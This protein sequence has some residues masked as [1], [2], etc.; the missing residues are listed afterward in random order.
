VRAAARPRGALVSWRPPASDGGSPVTGYVIT[1]SPGGKRARTAAVTSFTVGGLTNGTAYRFTVAAVT[2]AGTGPASHRSAA[3][4]PRASR[5]PGA[6]RS[7]AASAGY[8]QATVTWRAPASDGGAPVTSYVIAARPGPVTQR[9]AGDTRT[10]TLAGLRDGRRYRL[11]VSAVTSAGTGQA[12]ESA[13]VTPRTTVPGPP[14]GVTAAPVSSGVEVSWQPPASNGGSSVSSYVIEVTGTTRKI[15]VRAAARSVVITGLKKG[16]GYGFGVAARN[17]RGTGAAATS[18]RASAGGTVAAATVV[19]SAASLA[20]LAPAQPGG[21]LVFTSPPAQ[22]KGLKTGD[23]LVA[24]VAGATPAGLLARVTS[25]VSGGTKVTVSTVPAS[26]DQALSAAGFGTTAT[27]TRGQVA[28]FR[29]ARAGVRL[30]SQAPAASSGSISLSLDTDLYRAG[31]G[32]KVTLDGT[33]SLT[34]AMTFAASVTCC[35]HTASTFT[36]T[37][38]SA[39]S[40]DLTAQV[41]HDISGGYTLGTF[42]FD[43][44]A[45]DVL[46]VPVVIVPELTVR[47]LASGSVTAG[48]STAAGAAITVGAQVTTKD[49][50]VSAHPVSSRTGSF[51]P[52]VLYGSLAAAAGV[53]AA[54]SATVDGV[55]GVTLTDSLWLAK[56]SADI[57]ANPWWTLSAQ[58]VID[59]DLDLALL[60]HTFASYHATLSDVTARLA[61]APGPYQGITIT[62]DPAAVSPGG[63]LQLH[64]RV[65]GTAAQ[66]VTWAAPTGNGAITAAGRYTAPS[67]P[68]TYQVTASVPARGLSPAAA[69]E[70]SVQVGDQP[71]G[72]P[73]DAAA[74]AA[75]PGAARVTWAAPADTGGGRVTGYT[76]TA[77]PGGTSIQAAGTARSVSLAGLTPGS[78][79]T[80]TVA[81]TGA[82][83]AGLPSAATGPVLISGPSAAGITAYPEPGYS[84]FDGA[85]SGPDGRLWM[86][87]HSDVTGE[88]VLLSVNPANGTATAHPYPS[89]YGC[90]DGSSPAFDSAGNVW[91]PQC[92]GDDDSLLRF[93]PAT[94]AWKTF[95]VPGAISGS[96][97]VSNLTEASDG[98]VWLGYNSNV[99]DR[100]AP[101][102]TMTPVAMPGSWDLAD[103]NIVAGSDGTAWTAVNEYAGP[104]TPDLTGVAKVTPGGSVTVYQAPTADSIWNVIGDPGH[105]VADGSGESGHTATYS[106]Y[107]VSPSG[108]FAFLA[109]LND[110]AGFDSMDGSGNVWTWDFTDSGASLLKEIT[111]SGTVTSVSVE[112]DGKA[113][114]PYGPPVQAPDGSIWT[115]LD[116]SPGTLLRAA[117]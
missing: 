24:G 81:A 71:P 72:P 104:G 78:T 47:L 3:V 18:A 54:L 90:A 115:P 116:S 34:P 82:A 85:V 106:L 11:L 5:R 86:K 36:G 100:V 62:P 20:A 53:S 49:A 74:A 28:A 108:T 76:I 102:G 35:V 79:Y 107:T 98:D 30:L 25:V 48:L 59:L 12:A 70:I 57:G 38:T 105:L 96:L 77:S 51:A 10:A 73:R 68:G 52:P 40:L 41:S 117:P 8:R 2:G 7:V 23:I 37:M 32:R 69:G 31:N 113:V 94:G 84:L 63:Q 19:L 99:L 1:A 83:G 66:S 112:L 46:G 55:A 6:P 97:A 21:T 22:V 13:G 93:D 9:V 39:A 95:A 67:T 42:R 75:G 56:L 26:L 4:T 114:L 15:S 109:S 14:A 58:N 111:P 45:F 60:H 80:F 89:G 16:T 92:G 87:A 43:P 33:V 110:D 17:A 64:A 65:A 91:T 103:T 27:L 44:I 50:A 88:G 61:Q 101:D 29:P